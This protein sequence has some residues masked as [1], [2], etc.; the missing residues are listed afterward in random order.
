MSSFPGLAG[1]LL[2]LQDIPSSGN[3]LR[4]VTLGLVAKTSA[5]SHILPLLSLF[6]S[7]FYNHSYSLKHITGMEG[8]EGRDLTRE[9][10]SGKVG[11]PCLIVISRLF[12]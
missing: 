7:P 4:L 1:F 9:T 6:F 10:R 12:T 8:R 2:L 11:D 5:G 3:F